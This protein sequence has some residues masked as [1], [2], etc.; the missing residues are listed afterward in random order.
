[1]RL[2]SD[3]SDRPLAVAVYAVAFIA[4]MALQLVIWLDVTRPE[5]GD[6][7]SEPVPDEVGTGFGRAP[8]GMLVVFGAIMR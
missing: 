1:M 5:R 8:G 3:Y 7:L 4:A 2:L 6:L